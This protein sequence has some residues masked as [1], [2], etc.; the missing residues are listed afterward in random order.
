M[1]SARA[2]G[3]TGFLN[4]IPI[5]AGVSRETGFPIRIFLSLALQNLAVKRVAL[6][7]GVIGLTVPFFI[8]RRVTEPFVFL[9]TSSP[10]TSI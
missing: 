2:S 4:N 5:L 7:R 8:D 6:S 9:G 1:I 3:E 10:K